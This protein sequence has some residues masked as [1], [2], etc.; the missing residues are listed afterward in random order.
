MPNWKNGIISTFN[1]LIYYRKKNMFEEWMY[2]RDGFNWPFHKEKQC[3][4]F[5][6]LLS[7][8][9][10]EKYIKRLSWK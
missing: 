10:E 4:A 2:K 1:V 9:Q 6:N 8:K 5:H 3:H 7:P